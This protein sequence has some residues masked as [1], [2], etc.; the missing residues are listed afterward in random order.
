MDNLR[1][2][3]ILECSLRDGSYAIDFNFTSADTELLVNELSTIGFNWIEIGHGLGMGA[4]LAGKGVMPNNDLTLLKAARKKTSA[5]IGMFY[6]PS[7]SSIDQ[8]SIAASEGLDFVRIGANATEP[9]KAFSHISRAKQIGLTVGMN[10]MKSYAVSPKEFGVMARQA[11][12]AGADIIYLV[13]SVGGMTPNEVEEYFSETKKNCSCEM[14]FHGHDN[15]RMAVA[16]TLKAHECGARFLDATLMGIGRGAGNAPS[17]ALIC[18]LEESGIPTGIDIASLLKIADTYICPLMDNLTMYNTKE[19]AMGYGKFH[20]SHLPKIKKASLKYNADE[21]ELIITMGRIDPVNIDDKVLEEVAEKLK[22][23]KKTYESSALISYPGLKVVQDSISLNDEAVTELIKGIAVTCAKRRKATPVIEVVVL[24][25]EREGLVVA[26]HIWDS[27]RIVLG[28]LT[29]SNI[30]VFL[31]IAEL[32]ADST[33]KFIINTHESKSSPEDLQKI[34]SEV[35]PKRLFPINTK[36]LKKTFLFNTLTLLANQPEN[37]S[38]LIYGDDEDLKKHLLQYSSLEQ[39]IVVDTAATPT[40]GAVNITNI[41]DWA[42]LDMEVDLVYSALMPNSSTEKKL[43]KC[44]NSKSKIIS[45]FAAHC[46]NK[47]YYF[48]NLDTAYEGLNEYMNVPEIE[49]SPYG[50]A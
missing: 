36:Q 13:D 42:L 3:E 39:I 18:L 41:D 10:F 46:G 19:V 48:L 9:L 17:E 40:K 49:F 32:L 47:N 28:R 2:V 37:R 14:G 16:N 27:E 31:Q 23:T 26:E 20:S 35:G 43:L 12:E 5:N 22:D 33:F 45:P 1:N 8:L 4:S 44:L 29:V 50:D 24:E 21:K 6:I 30:S 38:I 11:V 25:A 15:L 34:I 7:L